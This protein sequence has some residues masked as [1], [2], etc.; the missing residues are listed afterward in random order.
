MVNTDLNVSEIIKLIAGKDAKGKDVENP[1]ALAAAK[2]GV[3]QTTIDYWIRGNRI[4]QWHWAKIIEL[5]Q[6]KVSA[7]HLHNATN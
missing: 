1:Q 2:I 4:P 3:H 5:T 7:E 6:G